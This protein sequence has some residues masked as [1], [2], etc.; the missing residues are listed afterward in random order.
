MYISPE[1]KIFRVYCCH[2]H[3]GKPEAFELLCGISDP[4]LMSIIIVYSCKGSGPH[5]YNM[6]VEKLNCKGWS[7]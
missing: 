6:H 5:I 4:V 1:T 3:N 2:P 7:L